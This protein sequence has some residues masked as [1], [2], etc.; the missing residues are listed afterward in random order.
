MTVVIAAAFLFVQTSAA[1]LWEP[2][3]L[4][5][6][7]IERP[8]A[9]L[10]RRFDGARDGL[11]SIEAGASPALRALETSGLLRTETVRYRVVSPTEQALAK[12][13]SR[14]RSIAKRAIPYI[15]KFGETFGVYAMLKAAGVQEPRVFVLSLIDAESGFNPE[16]RSPAG[17]RGLMQVMPSTAADLKL[18]GPLTSFR[19]NI[20][21]GMKYLARALH[22]LGRPD[23]A[24]AAYSAGIARVKSSLKRRGRPPLIE[25]TYNYVV[26][27]LATYA[28]WVGAAA[29]SIASNWTSLAAFD[30]LR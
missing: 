22:V 19:D 9:E 21:A 17:A 5:S 20:R 30:E 13:T 11:Q 18:H 26:R 29:V 7:L 2:A 15:D 10:D 24:L 8:T 27:I 25:E 14:R 28:E 1:K 16:A 12:L 3:G 23:Y 4:R 6:A